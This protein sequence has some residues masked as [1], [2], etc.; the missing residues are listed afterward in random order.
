M[1]DPTARAYLQLGQAGGPG[2]AHSVRAG[3]VVKMGACSL[4]VATAVRQGDEEAGPFPL[5]AAEEEATCYICFDTVTSEEDPLIKSP[6]V[7]T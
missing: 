4:M 1:V 7:C 3:N 2:G 5:E 6:C